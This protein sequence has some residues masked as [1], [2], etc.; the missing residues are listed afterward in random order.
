MFT[1]RSEDSMNTVQQFL[2]EPETI[3][4]IEEL[5]RQAAERLFTYPELTA[6]DRLKRGIRRY[7]LRQSVPPVDT[8]FWPHALLAGGLLEGIGEDGKCSCGGQDGA[9]G[10]PEGTSALCRR[11]VKTYLDGWIQAGQ[12]AWYL[13]NVMNADLLLLFYERTKDSVYLEAADRTAAYLRDYPVNGD[14][15]LSYRIRNE[16]QVFADGI[17]MICPFL[18]RFGRIRQNEGMLRLGL[19]QL[20]LFMEKGMD[21]ATGLPYHGYDSRTGVKQGCIGWGRAVGWLMLGM[22]DGLAAAGAA[23]QTEWNGA[24]HN[25]SET[26]RAERNGVIQNESGAEQAEGNLAVWN[27]R[28]AVQAVAG[29]YRRL[30][31]TVLDYQREDGSFAWLLPAMEGPADSSAAGMIAC[32]LLSGIQAGLLEEKDGDLSFDWNDLYRDGLQR[33]KLSQDTLIQDSLQ[34]GSLRQDCLQLRAEE[35]VLRAARFLRSCT[36]NGRVGASSAEC[37]G[38]AQYPQRYGNYP[39][40]DGPALRLFGMIRKDEPEA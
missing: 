36:R 40:A 9:G 15:S 21:A 29:H 22:A 18:C 4:T 31:R 5:T 32:A 30:V 25:R 6:K 8:H 20:L 12:P 39:W 14:G 7:F 17:G 24:V 35:A 28:E 2:R 1:L 34:Q 11:A 26:E 33:G 27:G 38:F 16:G 23:R 13:D 37:E 10:R 3:K 19:T